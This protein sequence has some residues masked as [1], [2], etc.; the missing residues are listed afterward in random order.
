MKK[1]LSLLM[2]LVFTF[3][4]FTVFAEEECSTCGCGT[5][6]VVKEATSDTQVNME[7]KKWYN[8]LTWF[9]KSSE[10]TVKSACD[11]S[12]SCVK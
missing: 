2:I 3:S 10:C 12:T 4:A 7:S 6:E 9:N 5:K 1:Y 8:P 11:T